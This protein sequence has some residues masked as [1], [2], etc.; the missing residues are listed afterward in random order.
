MSGWFLLYTGVV[1]LSW[2]F[3][4]SAPKKRP[5]TNFIMACIWPVAWLL[6]LGYAIGH[7]PK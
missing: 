2:G 5:V 1:F 7:R 3:F 4:I 6:I